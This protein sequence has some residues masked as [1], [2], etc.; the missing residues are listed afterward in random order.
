MKRLN[1]FSAKSLLLLAAVAT[2]FQ[3]VTPMYASAAN[4]ADFQAGRIID[5][6]VFFDP[7]G[8]SISE[9]QTFLSSKVPV[10]DT[11][12]TQPYAGTTRAAYGT[13]RGYPPPYTCLKDYVSQ[14]VPKSADSY[15]QGY[16][17]AYKTAAE[18]IHGVAQSCGINPR[19]LIVL[20]QKEQGLVTDDWP[21]SIQYRS[22]TGYGCPDTAACDSEYYGFFNQLYHAARQ[23]K[24]YA[25]LNSEYTYQAYRNNFIQWNPNASCGGSTVYIQNLATS[26]LYNYTPYRPN[27]AALNAG[28]GTGD[29]CSSYG[30]RNFWLYYTDWFGNT[31]SPNYNWQPDA[32]NAYTDQTKS[33]NADL[34]TFI[35]GRS[36]AYLTLRVKNN[37]VATW[38][39]NSVNLATSG[40]KD[41]SS[42][43]YDPSWL[44]PS[45]PATLVENSVAPGDYGT[46]EFW[47]NAPAAAGN[48]RE[49][50]NLVTE[51]VTWM[52]DM[53]LYYQFAVAP[54]RYTWSPA[55]QNVYT[56]QT[57]STAADLTYLRAGQRLYLVVRATN[58]GNVPW[59]KSSVNIGTSQPR[60][61]VSPFR[62]AAWYTSNRPATLV[63]NTVDPGE[64]GTFE[65]W[66]TVPSQPGAYREYY[67]LV[68]EGI[69]WMIDNGLYFPFN[70]NR[71]YD[72]AP[73]EQNAYTDQ[74]K[75][76]PYSLSTAT[77]GSRVYLQIKARNT[78]SGV[79]NKN[80]INV[81]TSQPRDRVSPFYDSAWL[82]SNRPATLVETSVNPG[83]IGTFEFWI[84]IPANQ[85]AGSYREYYS[86]VAE[87]ITWMIDYGLYYSITV[88]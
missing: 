36:R 17:P 79:W 88:Q 68:A 18:L 63:E 51:G 40:P 10:C 16:P 11:N 22:A 74:T 33:T 20:L 60:D 30:N 66:V 58:T 28:Y 59:N 53:G 13:S 5:D 3:L 39:K 57:K 48:Y 61:R 6:Q 37:G 32:Q 25:A 75:S 78:G 73:T 44:S 9:I 69:T 31:F 50:F 83:E 81:G 15:C 8:L 84:T 85:A 49:Y 87:G 12:G 4:P 14:T 76:T 77:K 34:G 80:T 54:Q 29:S 71:T 70:V 19:V 55:S 35:A 42:P 38:Y 86:L 24:R 52:N 62:D 56:D 7:N 64:T 23:F 1:I 26:G 72:W 43:F 47:V 46:F 82:S 65:F 27:Q 21:W 2:M 67:N 41:R 45:R